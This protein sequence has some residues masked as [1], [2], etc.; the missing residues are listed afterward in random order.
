M[1]DANE[2]AGTSGNGRVEVFIYT[3]GSVINQGIKWLGISFVALCVAAVGISWAGKDTNA[4]ISILLSV[5]EA[6]GGS[7]PEEPTTLSVIMD[8]VPWLVS[9]LASV[10]AWNERRLRKQVIA[11]LSARPRELEHIIDARRD[12]SGLLPNGTTPPRD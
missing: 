2:K 12:S 7:E 8:Y 9:G 6:L 1:S 11:R 4:L 10:L 5:P 3:A